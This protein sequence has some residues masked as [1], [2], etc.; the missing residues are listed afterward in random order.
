VTGRS[1]S[2][3][4]AFLSDVGGFS[5]KWL[6]DLA[7]D[8]RPDGTGH[9]PRPGVPPRATSAPAHWPRLEGSPAGV[10]PPSTSR[11]RSTGRPATVG[12]SRTSGPSMQAWVDFAA[13]A[14]ATRRHRSRTGALGEAA[15]H[16]RFLWDSGWHFGEWLE[17]G[18][19]LDDAI[20]AATGA[21]HG[22]SPPPTSSARPPARGHR[23]RPRRAGDAERYGELA[24]HVA[25]AWRTE[26]LAEDGT[27]T[28]DTQATYARALTFGL[29]PD[30]LRPA[31]A[32][33]LVE[34]VRAAGDPRRH[35]LPRHPVPAAGPRR[36]RP[37]RRRLRPPPPGQRAVVARH[38]RPRCHHRL[39]GVVRHRRRRGPARVAQPLQQG[40]RRSPSSTST[41]PASGSSSPATAAS[42]SPPGRAAGIEWVEAHHDSPYGRISV[43]WEQHGE[44]F[45]LE[46]GVPPGTTADVELPRA[47]RHG[48]AV[49]L[50]VDGGPGSR[51]WQGRPRSVTIPCAGGPR[52][53]VRHCPPCD[54]TCGPSS[55][56]PWRVAIRR[57]A[58]LRFLHRSHVVVS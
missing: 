16:E 21:D 29:I 33:R 12:S 9:E 34:L 39:G 1:S 30:E 15:P 13:G 37:P 50:P 49:A 27:T 10:T 42:A 32:D 45:H 18:E 3:P 2:R 8:Q 5:L 40:R 6:R 4:A 25:D 54:Q 58:H 7:A 53:D 11:G 28:P 56:A 48:P 19:R 23:P 24:A 44:R 51:R 38:G 26:F 57:Q 22:R 20:A 14:A 36:E 47:G 41:P 35:R 55:R 46:L 43:R 52:R 31:A 17:A